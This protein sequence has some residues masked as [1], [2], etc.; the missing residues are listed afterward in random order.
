MSVQSVYLALIHACSPHSQPK[1]FTEKYKEIHQTKAITSYHSVYII[2]R[3]KNNCSD[4]L[5]VSFLTHLYYACVGV[6]AIV[7]CV[8]EHAQC[9]WDSEHKQDE[10][11]TGGC[12]NFSRCQCN[13]TYCDSIQPTCSHDFEKLVVQK[14]NGQ[15]GSCCNLTICHKKHV[16]IR[17]HTQCK[18]D[19]ICPDVKVWCPKDTEFVRPLAS[20]DGCCVTGVV[21]QCKPCVYRCDYGFYP[22]LLRHGTGMPGDCCHKYYCKKG[23]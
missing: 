1:I 12:K 8:I 10:I 22:Q 23:A 18:S 15:P 6:H 14:G 20:G 2:N 11:D 13:Q 4:R 17:T 3:N 21:C 9:P 7:K 5:F 16:Q 19:V